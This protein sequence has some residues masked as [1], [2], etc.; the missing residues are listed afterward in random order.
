MVD[1]AVDLIELGGLVV[2]TSEGPSRELTAFDRV[3]GPQK[4]SSEVLA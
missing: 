2:V 3:A 1:H 4:A